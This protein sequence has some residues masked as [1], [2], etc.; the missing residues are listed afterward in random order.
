MASIKSKKF[1]VGS[2][3]LSQSYEEL[4][5]HETKKTSPSLIFL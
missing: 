1:D 5:G 4:F 2:G 3:K